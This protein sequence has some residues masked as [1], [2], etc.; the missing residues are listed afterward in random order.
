M[1]PQPPIPLNR[2]I[3]LLLP[4][5]LACHTWSVQ[6]Q[7]VSLKTIETEKLLLISSGA[8]TPKQLP[9]QAAK[10]FLNA[11]E[12][13]QS[14]FGWTSQEKIAFLFNDWSDRGNASAIPVPRNLV[15]SEMSPIN[16]TFESSPPVDQL[17][18]IMNHEV[19]HL[20]TLD[21][22]GKSQAFWRKAF[23]GK[24]NYTANHPETLLYG[25][26]TAP[27]VMA[28]AWIL[29]GIATFMET[30][31][32]GG[33]G[34]AQGGY[35][36][37][38]F[39]AKV[40]D[41]SPFYSPL[42][43]ESKGTKVDLNSGANSYLYGTRFMTYLA[44]AYSPEKLIKWFKLDEGDKSRYE[45][46]FKHVFG[47]SIDQAW[48]EWIAFEKTFQQANLERLNQFPPTRGEALS[49]R[50]VGW[51]SRVHLD[52]ESQS[53][54]GGFYAHG[55]L[56]SVGRFKLEENARLNEIYTIKGPMKF[57]VTSTAFDPVERILFFTED[58][59]RWRDIKT[60]DLKTDEIRTIGQDA[61]T[62]ELVFNQQ[63]RSLWGV[64][65]SGSKASLVHM[66]YPYEKRITVHSPPFAHTL[67]DLDISADGR[68]LSAT[69][70]D[71]QGNQALQVFLISDLKA[72]N[73][74]PINTFEFGR[75][76]PEDFV[77]DQAGRFLYGT[78]YY[79]GV[80]NVFRFEVET[81]DMEAITNAETGFFRPLPMDDGSLIM[82]EYTGDGFL[83]TRLN[84]P[85]PLKDL[86]AI[87][88]LGSELVKTHP[89]V[90]TWGAGSPDRLELE[91]KIISEAPYVPLKRIQFETAYP[92]VEGYKDSGALGYAAR[93]SDPLNLNAI[94]LDLSYSF[95]KDLPQ[96]EKIHVDLHYRHLDW[97]VRYWHN[98]ADF[99]DLFGPTKRSRKGDALSVSYN[100][101]VTYDPPKRLDFSANLAYY[102]GLDTLP[103]NQNIETGINKMWSGS[104]GFS[105][106][107]TRQ[108]QGAVDHEKGLRWQAQTLA[109]YADNNVY[110]KLR[111]GLDLGFELP[112]KHASLWL[113]S[114]G[115]AAGGDRADVFSYYYFGGFGN[116]YVDDSS[117]KRYRNYSSLP[118]FDIGE[119]RGKQFAKS[120]LELNLP[121]IRFNEL[122]TQSFYLSHIRPAIFAGV[123]MTDP[124]HALEET[125]GTFG[126]QIDLS[127]TVLYRL[128]M[129]ISVG[130]AQG[131]AS[132]KQGKTEWMLSLKIL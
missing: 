90:A 69:V 67:S 120:M 40:R 87:T 99:Y 25:H 49:A 122:G 70:G 47:L 9:P 52:T 46:Q 65:H 53:L 68:M 124:G 20:A 111:L 121:P 79:T 36:E 112:L 24:V 85:K 28:P 48:A 64:R 23:G 128:P 56:A 117:V 60:W 59:A 35:D 43:L 58:N 10:S 94:E 76:F 30:W 103:V 32:S 55:S 4:L 18:S 107:D 39:R 83:P 78:S 2:F 82:F 81:G 131:I 29:E 34:R 54:V 3:G 123:L 44:Y 11:L 105:Y 93:W 6:A 27:R 19:A 17:F 22:H 37:M 92:M 109:D 110:P 21:A 74:N 129:T 15:I 41:D 97:S 84:D 114:A 33:I 62:G 14:L 72:Q 71:R 77:F 16:K 106:S 108:S 115:G 96:K 1:R 125:Y 7:S 88:F 80:S 101:A 12:F 130:V 61:R 66:P 42:G 50:G 38:M 113:Y 100:T 126:A 57:N 75:A 13:H 95:D 116:N 89:V 104:A 118:G 98:D 73:V 5:V 86:S 102:T 91:S 119:I 45:N 26:L 127:F 8:Q 51:V 132:G 31:M 63:D